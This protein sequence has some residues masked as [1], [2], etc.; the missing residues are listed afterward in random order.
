FFVVGGEV[1]KEGFLGGK[2][3][4][5]KN[6]P[7]GLKKGKVKRVVKKKKKKEKEK[8][9]KKKEKKKKKSKEKKKKKKKKIY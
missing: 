6:W 7:K 1:V 9:K 2:H 4:Q 3:S 8:Q 5:G